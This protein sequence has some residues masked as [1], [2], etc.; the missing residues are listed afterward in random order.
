MSFAIDEL[1]GGFAPHGE[2]LYAVTH[3]DAPN[4]KVVRTKLKQ[5]DWEHAEVVVPEAKDS[6]T[7]LVKSK[8]YLFVAYS[9]GINGRLVKY[10][11]ATGE[12]S[13]V[14]LPAAGTVESIVRIGEAIFAMW[15]SPPG[16][17]RTRVMITTLEHDTFQKSEF[18]TD[19]AYPGSKTLS[20]KKSKS[21]GTMALWSRSRS[22]IKKGTPRDGSNSCILKWL[23]RLWN[24]RRAHRSIFIDYSL[25]LRGVVLAFAHPRGGG[26]KGEAWYKAGYKT[27]KPNTWKDFISCAA[28]SCQSRIHQPGQTRRHGNQRWRHPNFPRRHRAA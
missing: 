9:D 17:C 22:F 20:P 4:Y 1:V 13:D 15:S 6:I 28:V 19:V 21:Q 18:H 27:T 2:Y 24:Q 26:E 11:F 8:N 3:S 14:K 5:P 23:R 7:A 25:A 10:D 12:K 16:R